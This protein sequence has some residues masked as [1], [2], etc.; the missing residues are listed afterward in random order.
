MEEG[1]PLSELRDG[2]V[3]DGALD[4][5]RISL[6]GLRIELN[7]YINILQTLGAGGY[8]DTQLAAG[9]LDYGDAHFTCFQFDYDWRRDIVD[10]ARELHEYILARR[11]YVKEEV[12]E[13]FGVADYEFKFDVVAHSMGGLVLRY[14]LRYGPADLPAGCWP[15]NACWCRCRGFPC[16][17][18][19]VR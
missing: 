10:S 7:A 4:Q 18:R 19:P 11:R 1:A 9:G 15:R 5:I 16:S 3:P 6:L 13:R 12:L 17:D 8:R 14:Y 2:V